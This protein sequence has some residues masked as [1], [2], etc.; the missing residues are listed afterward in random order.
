MNAR[1][2]S[3][4]NVLDT[5]RGEKEDAFIV[6][7]DTQEDRHHLIPLKVMSGSCLQEDVRFIQKQY[8]F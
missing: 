6:F 7:Q 5:V 4:I 1:M 3:V 8:R 2:E